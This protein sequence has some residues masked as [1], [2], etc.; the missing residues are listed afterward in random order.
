MT[1]PNDKMN[2]YPRSYEDVFIPRKIPTVERLL[3][4]DTN[5]QI[6]SII[7]GKPTGF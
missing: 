7:P 3:R 4:N 1:Q 6:H 2:M 5:F